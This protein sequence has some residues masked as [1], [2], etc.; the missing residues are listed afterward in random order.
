MKNLNHTKH[1]GFTLIEL[2]V[3]LTL[4]LIA[5]LAIFSTVSSFEAQRRTTGSGADMQQNGL[6]ALYS[7]EQDIRMAGYGLIDTTTTPGNLPCAK[8]NAYNPASVFNASPVII[9]NGSTGNDII[10]INRLSSDTGGI[11]TGGMAAHLSA[12]FSSAGSMSLDT[13]VAINANDFVVV[14]QPGLDCTLLKVNSVSSSLTGGITVQSAGNAGADASQTPGA[15]PSYA[16]A[17]SAA[18]AVLINLGPNG[19]V[20]SSNFG[21]SGNPT[22]AT[23]KYRIQANATSSSYD[24]QRTTDN[25]ATNSVVASNIVNVSAQYGINDAPTSGTAPTPQNVTHWIDATG[26][27]YGGT[28]WA[29]LSSVADVKRI[30]AIRV[31]IVARSANKEACTTTT[32]APIWFA[33]SIDLS[34]MS[35]WQCYR[36]KV[37]QTIIPIRNVIWGNFQ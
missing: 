3:G 31:A 28:D 14:A 19:V 35:D 1:A 8:I 34:G 13:N 26:N 21:A 16:A 7:I 15:F 36:Y 4:G 37:Y 6:L 33:G 12:P 25:W 23:T 11:V 18:S 10:A 2:M 29:T 32:A 9:V 24:L 22:F 30:K 20:S 27:S 5:S 17:G